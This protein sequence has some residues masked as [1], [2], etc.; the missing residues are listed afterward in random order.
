MNAMI[1]EIPTFGPGGP[2]SI[3]IVVQPIRWERVPLA[4]AQPLCRAWLSLRGAYHLG[5]QQARND[6]TDHAHHF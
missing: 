6:H 2:L 1:L 5:L 4:A 3:A